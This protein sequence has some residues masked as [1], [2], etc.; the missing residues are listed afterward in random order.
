MNACGN[1]FSLGSVRGKD[2][3]GTQKNSRSPK[4]ARENFMNA[5]GNKFSLGSVR[6]K[7]E[8]GTQNRR[9]EKNEFSTLCN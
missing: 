4:R 6:G 5:C 9:K 1:K 7:D 8:C 3:C 2:E